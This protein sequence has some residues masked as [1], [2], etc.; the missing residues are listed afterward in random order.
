MRNSSLNRS[1]MARVNEGSHS[2][3]CH[4]HVY[5][6]STSEMN[7]TCLNCPAA[8]HLHTLAGTRFPPRWGYEV[9]LAC[10]VPSLNGQWMRKGQGDFWGPLSCWRWESHPA[11]E[12]FL[13]VAA[14][15]QE[16]SGWPGMTWNIVSLSWCVCRWRRVTRWTSVQRV[17]TTKTWRNFA[18]TWTSTNTGFWSRVLYCRHR[19]FRCLS[20]PSSS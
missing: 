19:Y 3:T 13:P 6:V 20:P 12:N 7:H 8:E 1:G 16:P 15:L 4:P 14:Q 10:D 17:P 18:T 9:E 5:P 2:F 11:T